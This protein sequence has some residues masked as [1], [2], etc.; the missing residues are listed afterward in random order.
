M[1]H[2]KVIITAVG[3]VFTLAACVGAVAIT[4]NVTDNSRNVYAVEVADKAAFYTGKYDA[5]VQTLYK[6]NV[7]DADGV[8]IDA[9]RDEEDDT[10]TGIRITQDGETISEVDVSPE[11]PAHVYL[12]VD[13]DGNLD[14]SVVS[15]DEKQDEEE[16]KPVIVDGEE[17]YISQITVVAEDGSL[18][19]H[20]QKGDTLC[21]ISR[22]FGYSVQELAEYNHISNP[23]LIYAD[24]SLRIPPSDKSN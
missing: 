17:I 22:I 5:Y 6:D 4:K 13:D 23:N 1:K 24:S 9:R 2:E 14:V 15:G 7:L 20:I 12:E 21:R 16:E 10:I 19:Y 8:Q 18:I 11:N 3:T